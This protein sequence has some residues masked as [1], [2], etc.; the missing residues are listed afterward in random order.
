MGHPDIKKTFVTLKRSYFRHNSMA[1][2]KQAPELKQESWPRRLS[3]GRF[4]PSKVGA[5]HLQDKLRGAAGGPVV[6]ALPCLVLLS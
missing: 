5:G 3:D 6:S 1:L 2:L 4:R